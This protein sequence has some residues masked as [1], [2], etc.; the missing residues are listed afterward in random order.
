MISGFESDLPGFID[1]SN[2]VNAWLISSD[3]FF[4]GNNA[5]KNHPI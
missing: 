3:E 1:F 2:Y 5:F 4:E